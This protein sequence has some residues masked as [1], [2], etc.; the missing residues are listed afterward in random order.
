MRPP[1]WQ[2]IDQWRYCGLEEGDTVLIHSSCKRTFERFARIGHRIEVDT[3]LKSFLEAV[4]KRGTV[5]FPTFNFDFCGG[6]GYDIRKTPSKMGILTEAARLDHNSVRNGHPAYSFATI[7]YHAKA[8]GMDNYR[9]LGK[10]SP[11][12]KLTEM[13]GKIA[14]LDINEQGSMT[15][16][17]HVDAMEQVPWRFFKVFH[18]D[19]TDWWGETNQRS[20][21]IYV[22]KRSLGVQTNINPM[23]DLLWGAE[24]YTGHK[25]GIKS[26]F[27]VAKARE[28][29]DYIKMH[30][31]AGMAE[32]LSYYID[33]DTIED[34]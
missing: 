20:Y 7:G 4:G 12:D 30:Y 14:C 13:D 9:G 10:G 18:G 29:Y 21:G 2:L 6:K 17:H 27:R 34:D 26:G 22:R 19:Y 28:V 33:K 11:F 1:L 25:P 16:H 31:D 32:G 24:I 3:I 5:L 15:Y 23:G 8:F